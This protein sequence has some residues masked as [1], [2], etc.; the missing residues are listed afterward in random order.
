VVLVFGLALLGCGSKSSGSTDPEEPEEPGGE[1]ETITVFDML[2]DD[3]PIQK[4]TVGPLTIDDGN[5]PNPIA[6]LVKAGNN[7][8]HVTGWQAVTDE[9]TGKIALQYTTA[10]DWGVG[11]DL[12]LA[13]FGF[14]DGDV[15]TVTGKVI[16]AQKPTIQLNSKVGAAPVVIGNKDEDGGDFELKATLTAAD[17]ANIKLGNPQTIRIECRATGVTVRITNITIVGE[18]PTD[19][20]PLAAPVIALL[21]DD[22]LDDDFGPVGIKW[23]AIAGAGGYEIWSVA[24]GADPVKL[25]TKT[26]TEVVLYGY[27]ALTEG[28]SYTIYIIAKGIEGSSKDSE[29]SNEVTYTKKTPAKP[30]ITIKVDGAEK[31]A[32]ISD[33]NGKTVAV[34]NS[35]T[36]TRAGN[37]EGSYNYF[38]VDFGAGKLS[39]FGK[40]TFKYQGVTGDIGW[41]RIFIVA[42]A[43]P[44]TGNLPKG[45]PLNASEWT[46]SAF[47]NGPNMGT[48]SDLT[49][50]ENVTL[51][52]P[53]TKADNFAASPVY[54]SIYIDAGETGGTPSAPTAI[55]ISD[56]AFVKDGGAVTG[57]GTL[58]SIKVKTPPTKDTYADTEVFAPAGLVITGNYLYGTTPE[59]GYAQDIPYAISSFTFK[60]SANTAITTATVMQTVYPDQTVT[61]T[62]VYGGKEATFDVDVGDVTPSDFDLA[63]GMTTGIGKQGDATFEGGI[64]TFPGTGSA[65]FTLDL[66]SATTAT[67]SKVITITYIC[68]SISGTPQLTLK[69]GGWG[70]IATADGTDDCDWYP[71]LTPDVESTLVLKE[72]WYTD[73]TSTISFQASSDTAVTKI[74]IISVTLE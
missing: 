17:I 7:G 10:A 9:G 6:P 72:G 30:I 46:G 3:C 13:A 36:F 48:G 29:K 52:I 18:R 37:Y 26:G 23:E 25:D 56:I 15:I 67:G 45:N 16:G 28:T 58:D 73:A 51:I 32:E 71:T 44:F 19:I 61:I 41:K 21:T 69:D 74:K 4:L 11:V 12:R 33:V 54:F 55:K 22:D 38:A 59:T 50:I 2:D 39:D 35:Y 62:V 24:A 57:T 20:K 70:S 27:D 34:D 14:R 66:P 5:G 53:K 1:L 8:E 31:F 40:I 68:K 60:D 64:I 63:T 47:V 43:T 65:L 42:S 49:A